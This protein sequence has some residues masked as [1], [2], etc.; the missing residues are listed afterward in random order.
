MANYYKFE[1]KLK[2]FGV[3]SYQGGDPLTFLYLEEENYIRKLRA[4]NFLI[5]T[6]EGIYK[7]KT[8]K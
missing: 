2:N 4:I 5:Q 6:L 3:Q 7:I 8:S 1:P